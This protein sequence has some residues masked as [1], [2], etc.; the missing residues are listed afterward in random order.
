MPMSLT[1]NEQFVLEF[2][3]GHRRRGRHPR[4]VYAEISASD[5]TRDLT[6]RDVWH[7]VADLLT[8]REIVR[9][10]G[11]HRYARREVGQPIAPPRKI[12]ATLD[13][14]ELHRGDTEAVI[15]AAPRPALELRRLREAVARGL[16]CEPDDTA[17]VVMLTAAGERAL[18][19]YRRTERR[20]MTELRAMAEE[21]AVIERRR[22]AA[23]R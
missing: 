9:T 20:R 13:L 17:S 15:A 11:R 3:P 10:V 14:V 16:L 7:I 6:L 12:G 1:P 18:N 4:E 19:T 2:F 22:A 21:A 5:C 23:K 8:A